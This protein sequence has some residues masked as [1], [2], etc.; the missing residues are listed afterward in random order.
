MIAVNKIIEKEL[1][2]KAF[3]YEIQLEIDDKYFIDEIEK[4]LAIKKFTL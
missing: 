3:L 1:L 2:R 4:S